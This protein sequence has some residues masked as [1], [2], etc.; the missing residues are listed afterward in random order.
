MISPETPLPFLRMGWLALLLHYLPVLIAAFL[1]AVNGSVVN[2]M[3]VVFLAW[4]TTVLFG[5]NPFGVAIDILIPAN[6]AP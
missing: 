1:V 3:L 2:S 4:F 5:S 6:A